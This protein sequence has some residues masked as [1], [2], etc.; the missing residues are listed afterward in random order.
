MSR[1]DLEAV[2][3]IFGGIS[4]ACWVVVFSPQIIQNFRNK[5]ADAVSLPFLLI[6]LVGD[7]FN[8]VGSVLQKVLT[9]MIVLAIYYTIADVILIS[10]TLFYRGFNVQH[11]LGRR[12]KSA[13]N[14]RKHDIETSSHELP[15]QVL[16]EPLEADGP[17][18]R[19]DSSQSTLVASSLS[20]RV[21]NL[22]LNTMFILLVAG[23]GSAGWLIHRAVTGDEE[24]D[25]GSGDKPTFDVTGQVFGYLSAVTYTA[26]RVPQLLLNWRRKT[27]EGLSMLFFIFAVLGNTTYIVSI[28]AYDPKCELKTCQPGEASNLYKRYCLVNLSWLLGSF[29]NLM[30]DFGIFFQFFHYRKMNGN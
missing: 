23:I 27:T 10:Q 11:I 4:I 6:W 25:T 9:S 3:G 28:L 18:Q 16:R 20:S 2:S 21:R 30:E 17:D 24:T 26:S 8:V 7:I 12:T 15:V 1:V 22:A 13:D 19:D 5:K 14:I 29:I